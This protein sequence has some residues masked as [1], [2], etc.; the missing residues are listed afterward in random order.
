M[1][2]PEPSP[3]NIHKV[4]VKVISPEKIVFSDEVDKVLLPCVN[5]DRMILPRHAPCFCAV[6]AGRLV[7]FDGGQKKVIIVSRGVAE[8]RRNICAIMAWGALP[9]KV[10]R[11]E[12]EE[13][14]KKATKVLSSLHTTEKQEAVLER[15]HFLNLLKQEL[16]AQGDQ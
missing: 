9:E 13:Q 12:L 8:I 4:R 11:P 15:V 16:D 7:L 6:K 1:R 14:I 3:E 10:E 2:D 5:G